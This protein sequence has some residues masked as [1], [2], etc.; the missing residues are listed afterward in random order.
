MFDLLRSA[1]QDPIVLSSGIETGFS[2]DKRDA[3]IEKSTSALPFQLYCCVPCP[4][5]VGV[6]Q[7][8]DIRR[9]LGMAATFEQAAVKEWLCSF[10][11]ANDALRTGN[12]PESV[13]ANIQQHFG[14]LSLYAPQHS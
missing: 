12:V 2:Y 5:Q 4:Q 9:L 11:G 1:S 10:S 7:G 13:C 6:V 14:E 3:Q 8:K